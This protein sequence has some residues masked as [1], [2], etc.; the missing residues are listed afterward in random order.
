MDMYTSTQTNTHTDSTDTEPTP[1]SIRTA[2][3][4]TL[5]SHSN[6]STTAAQDFVLTEDDS[7]EKTLT[8]VYFCDVPF[9]GFAVLVV[10]VNVGGA[11]FFAYPAVVTTLLC[12]FYLET[13][14]KV[15]EL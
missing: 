2:T 7:S 11:L 15:N 12:L 6:M 10:E 4:Y 1:P 14:L 13:R 9:L 5:Q 3:L 8:P